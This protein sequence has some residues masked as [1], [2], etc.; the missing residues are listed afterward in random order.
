MVS[1]LIEAGAEVDGVRAAID[2]AAAFQLLAGR[3]ESDDRDAEEAPEEPEG[4]DAIGDATEPEE[5]LEGSER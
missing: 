2:L 1:A 5:R 4:A 3:F